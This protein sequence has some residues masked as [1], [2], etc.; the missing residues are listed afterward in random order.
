MT[1]EESKR[2][3]LLEHT[4]FY[5]HTYARARMHTYACTRTRTRT[6]TYTVHTH[7]DT[8]RGF[9]LLRRRIVAFGARGAGHDYLLF[10]TTG[11][12][13]HCYIMIGKVKT[14]CCRIMIRV[15]VPRGSWLNFSVPVTMVTVLRL[16]G[17]LLVSVTAFRA[18]HASSESVEATVSSVFTI[19]IVTVPFPA[20]LASPARTRKAM[21]V[22][23]I[24]AKYSN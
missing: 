13:A 18:G 8:R 4:H 24:R 14:Q 19:V 17:T 9:A 10:A 23:E 15:A 5:A 20:R 11:N 16:P 22:S 7:H 12:C 2:P 1:C 21:T 3:R 6:R